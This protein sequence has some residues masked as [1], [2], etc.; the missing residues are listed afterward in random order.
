MITS[1]AVTPTSRRIQVIVNW[2]EEF[3]RRLA[4]K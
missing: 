4:T 1:P 3:Q 2:L